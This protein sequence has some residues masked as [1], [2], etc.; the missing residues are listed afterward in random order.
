MPD[1]NADHLDTK[2]QIE[3][4]RRKYG[5]DDWLQ[6]EGGDKVHEVLGIKRTTDGRSVSE[7]IAERLSEAQSK[8][9]DIDRYGVSFV[10]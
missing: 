8:K 5:K 10:I 1:E 4:L 2:R 3:E 6:G 9:D 7:I